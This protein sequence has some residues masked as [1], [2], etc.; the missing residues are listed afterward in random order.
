MMML[1]VY[2]VVTGA[3]VAAA[4]GRS[5]RFRPLFETMGGGLFMAGL[6]LTGAGLALVA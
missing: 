4:A 5:A 3:C 2:F 6:G 1:G